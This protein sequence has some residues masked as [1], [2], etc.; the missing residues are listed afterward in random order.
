MSTFGKGQ[1]SAIGA[2][3][4]RFRGGLITTVASALLPCRCLATD[5]DI[6]S[7]GGTVKN[8][9]PPYSAILG[10]NAPPPEIPW[11]AISLHTNLPVPPPPS[12]I[13]VLCCGSMPGIQGATATWTR[14]VNPLQQCRHLATN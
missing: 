10:H 6:R 2:D 13:P 14:T 7:Q 12:P 11:T 1:Q 3:R 9:S 8:M 4:S 5:H